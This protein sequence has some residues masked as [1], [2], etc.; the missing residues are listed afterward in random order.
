[1]VAGPA[2]SRPV[3]RRLPPESPTVPVP[4]KD[5]GWVN[6]QAQLNETVKKNQD[7]EL[8][9]IG[10]SITHA[11]ESGGKEV[12]AKFYAKRHAIN[13]GIG[14]DQTQHVLWRLDHG[15]LEGLHPKLAVVMIGTNNA[16][17]GHKPA[18]IADGVKA[19]VDK[20]QAEVP[21]C[22]VLI[23]AIFPRD[24]KPD[25]KLRKVNEAANEL[26]AKLADN[27]KIFYLDIGPKF[28]EADGTLPSDI[29]PDSLHPNAKGYE[30]WATAIEPTVA[31]L[32]G[33][34]S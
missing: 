1:M 18:Q 13:L 19:V 16:G 34:S 7:A 30:I 25:G 5:K 24:S 12:W 31:K 8:L 11:W 21:E 29:M 27:K 28:L 10:D 9:F 17:R 22:K 6:R 32:L 33:E 20:L 3:E 2:V 23:L 26:I 4:R 15:N 14:G